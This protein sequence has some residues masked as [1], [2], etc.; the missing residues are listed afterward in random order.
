[1]DDFGIVGIT[2]T[3]AV[4]K[5]TEFRCAPYCSQAVSAQMRG[6]EDVTEDVVSGWGETKAIP[7]AKVG[8]RRLTNLHRIRRNLD[9]NRSIFCWKGCGDE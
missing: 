4:E 5:G 2:V 8:R 3:G 6:L 1:M 7:I 9:R